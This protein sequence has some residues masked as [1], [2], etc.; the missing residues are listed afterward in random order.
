[1]LGSIR[2]F[3]E[4]IYAKILLGIIILPFIFWGMGNSIRGGNKNIVVVID[5]EKYSIQEFSEFIKRTADKKVRADHIDSFLSSFIGEKLVEKE[6]E[7]YGIKLSDTS[8]SKLIKHQKGFKKENKFSRV[9]YEKFLLKNN[10][11]ALTFE[12]MLS[13]EEKKKQLL[14]FI[15]GGIV[16]SKFLINLAYNKINQERSIQMIN[17][18]DVFKKELTF[19][20]DQIKIYFENN[21][22]KYSEVYKSLTMLELNP[23]KLTGNTEFNDLFFKK[24]DEIDDLIADGESFDNILKKFNLEKGNIFTINKNGKDLKTKTSTKLSQ[25]LINKIFSLEEEEP[26]SLIE[27]ENKYFIINLHNTEDIQK[28]LD[29]SLV[30]KEV[31]NDLIKTTRM[32]LTSEIIDKIN[33]NILNKKE[34]DQISKDKNVKITK[35]K[36]LSQNDTKILKKGIIKQ[37]YSFAENRIIVVNDLG[38]EENYLIYI[39]KIKNVKINENSDDYQKYL[40]LAR[41]KIVNDLYNTYDSY[42]NNKYKIEINYQALDTVKNYFN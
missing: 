22:E 12:L 29:E 32:K 38:L 35:I 11:T 9:E 7:N 16:P 5:E 31:T 37:I 21:K 19:S 36:L 28:N 14:E 8:L 15:G 25:N 23:K 6:V 10:I 13:K 3:S 33:K 41:I 18:N 2:K 20:Q 17:L 1:M 39:D 42:L 30:K 34:F 4:T 26:S 40:N 24:V 27:E